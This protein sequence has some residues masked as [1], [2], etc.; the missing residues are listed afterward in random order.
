MAKK[1]T[2]PSV[3]DENSDPIPSTFEGPKMDNLEDLLKQ[4][5]ELEEKIRLLRD[6]KKQEKIASIKS[7]MK[8][9]GI[10]LE[11]LM[12]AEDQPKR[13]RRDDLG[14]AK[15]SGVKI[16]YRDSKGNTWSGRG[17]TPRWITDSGM[18]KEHFRI[19]D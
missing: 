2:L 18:P 7:E 19:K 16:K 6:T 13:R 10:S 15:P 14:T 12:D 4:Q 11:D 1:L 8:I 3:L 9:Y 17:R 5:H